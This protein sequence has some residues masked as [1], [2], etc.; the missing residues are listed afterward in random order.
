[1]A[2]RVLGLAATQVNFYFIAIFFA[3]QLS[4]GAISAVS[5][6]WLIVMTPLGIVG[7]AISTAAFPTLAEHAAA[8]D[9]RLAPTLSG[10]L[11]LI[12]YLSLPMGVGL[13]LLAKPLTV[14]L[15][16][17][18]A[19]N[20]ESTRLTSE[21]LL[22]YAGALFAHSGIEILSRG[23][24]VMGD[25][26]TPVFAALVGMVLNLVLAAL[27]VGPWEVRGL[28][29]ALS[30]ATAAEFALLF[31]LIAGR[32]PRLVN[33]EL[34]NALSR[35]LLATTVMGLVAG[36][37]IF[38][39]SSAG[40]DFDRSGPALVALVVGSSTGAVTYLIATLALGLT[41][42]RQLVARLRP[43]RATSV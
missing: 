6:A 3:S 13:M 25:T 7:M 24:Y 15:L 40:L 18:G 16:Q 9:A 19:F 8:G 35:M 12:L 17:H 2:P 38:A 22:F 1:M 27:L 30:I 31:G 5:F 41:E 20:V 28:A 11:R 43:R 39:L 42:P 14:V 33:R 36:G 29:L 4:E 37:C 21:A 26:R 23:F 10:A 32:I 34:L